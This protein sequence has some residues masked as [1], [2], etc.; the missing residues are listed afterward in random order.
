[1]EQYQASDL[2]NQLMILAKV[3]AFRSQIE[4]TREN[5]KKDTYLQNMSRSKQFSNALPLDNL[6]DGKDIFQYLEPCFN[7]INHVIFYT[8]IKNINQNFLHLFYDSLIDACK[9]GLLYPP[10]FGRYCV[11][12]RGTERPRK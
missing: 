2:R 8:H 10:C 11:P 1:M 12:E 4:K 9:T 5:N 3:Q 6:L 7:H